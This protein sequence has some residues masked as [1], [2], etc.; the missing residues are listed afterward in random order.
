MELESFDTGAAV[1]RPLIVR[2]KRTHLQV[3]VLGYHDCQDLQDVF[4]DGVIVDAD[5]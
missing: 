5:E 1:G 3:L 2:T 4:W